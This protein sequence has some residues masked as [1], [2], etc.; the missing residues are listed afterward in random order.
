MI[1]ESGYDTE[2]EEEKSDECSSDAEV[3]ACVQQ[4][5][6]ND[7]MISGGKSVSEV[8]NSREDHSSVPFLG[9]GG[10]RGWKDTSSNYQLENFP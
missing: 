6:H 3:Y 4:N 7:L 2:R 10:S 9:G 5:V 1:K 8:D